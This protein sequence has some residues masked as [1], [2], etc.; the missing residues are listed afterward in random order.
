MKAPL[1]C[2][3]VPPQLF[4][5]VHTDHVQLKIT[6]TTYGFTCDR[7]RHVALLRADSSQ[8]CIRRRNLPGTNYRFVGCFSELV[9]DRHKAFTGKLTQSLAQWCA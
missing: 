2:R 3:D 1:H 7:R 6:G 5:R 4:Q 8:E 9:S